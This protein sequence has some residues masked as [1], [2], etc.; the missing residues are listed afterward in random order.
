MDAYRE[1]EDILTKKTV[2]QE[3]EIDKIDVKSWDRHYPYKN[4][5]HRGV[6]EYIP[7][8]EDKLKVFLFEIYKVS[9]IFG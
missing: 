9:E 3:Q 6:G 4:T 2:R 8:L 7:K 5:S 1:I